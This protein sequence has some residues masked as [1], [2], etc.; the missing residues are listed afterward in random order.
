MDISKEKLQILSQIKLLIMDVD[1]TLTDGKIYIGNEGEMMKAFN[2]KD[3]YIISRCKDYDIFTAIITGRISEIV[4]LRA[5]VLKVTDVFQGV[6]N[7]PVILNKIADKHDLTLEQIAY[8]GDDLN[9]LECMKLCGFSA[10]PHDASKEICDYVDY[11]CT[12]DGGNGAVREFLDLMISKK[13]V[14]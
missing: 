4:S 12:K 7:K 2:A 8:I 11:V 14:E 1:G 10:C 5:K 3:G 9:D 13:L 6:T